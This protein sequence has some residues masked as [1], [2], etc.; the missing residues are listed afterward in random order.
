M[1]HT[2]GKWKVVE[3]LKK[4]NGKLFHRVHDALGDTIADIPYQ[5]MGESSKGNA[6]LISAAPELLEACRALLDMV[7]NNRTHGPEI[8]KACQVIAK[9]EGTEGRDEG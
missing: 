9:A 3:F 8:D 2:P 5:P 7:T 4:G 6:R 1:K